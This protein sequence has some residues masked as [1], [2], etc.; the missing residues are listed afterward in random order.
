MDQHKVDRIN[1]LARKSK[2]EGLTEDEK[3]EQKLLR[4]EFIA[5]YRKNLEAQLNSLVIVDEKGN[6]IPVRKKEKHQ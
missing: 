2:A 6:R 4:E 3:A 5:S 1:F